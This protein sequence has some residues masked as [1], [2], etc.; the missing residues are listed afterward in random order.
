MK[1]T[2]KKKQPVKARK[3]WEDPV[4]LRLFE[5]NVVGLDV[6]VPTVMHGLRPVFVLPATQEAYDAMV[7]QMACAAYND[8]NRGRR[9]MHGVGYRA[10]SMKQWLGS[11]S[12]PHYTQTKEQCWLRPARAALAA[13]GITK[14]A[15]DAASENKA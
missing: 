1:S 8:S 3:L 9:D 10:L 12:G 11:W 6:G 2:P 14:P 13:I 4:M 15:N 5:S 7:E